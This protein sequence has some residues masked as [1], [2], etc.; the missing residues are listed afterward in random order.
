MKSEILKEINLVLSVIEHLESKQWKKKLSKDE[1]ELL[2]RL[3]GKVEELQ[4][5]NQHTF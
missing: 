3:I 5:I 1:S 2:F 4:I